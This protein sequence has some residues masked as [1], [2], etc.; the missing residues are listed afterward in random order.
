MTILKS[1]VKNTAA[2]SAAELVN[3]LGSALFWIAVV[4]VLG[5][6]GLGSLSFAMSLFALFATFSTFG[7]GAVLIR[8]VARDRSKAG[9]YFGHSMLLGL[10]SAVIAAALMN[11]AVL[12]LDT[13]R[14]T[15]LATRIMTT[16][17]LPASLFYWSKALLSAAEEMSK[18]ALARTAENLFKIGAGLAVLLAGGDLLLVVGVVAASK[19]VSA[20]VAF[21]YA[22]RLAAPLWRP[23]RPLLVYLLR[24]VPTFSLISI[25]NS[26]IWTMPVILLTHILGEGAAGV[27]SAAFKLVDL[28]LTFAAAYGQ[29]LFPIASRTLRDNRRV[30]EILFAKSVKV[31]FGAS[32]AL[33]AGI[34]MAAPQLVA[35][36]YGPGMENVASLLRLLVWMLIPYSIV[37]ILAHSLVSQYLQNRDLLANFLAAVAVISVTA[38][39]ASSL[40]PVSAAAGLLIGSTIFVTVELAAF[41]QRL[42]PIRLSP[43]MAK[44]ALAALFMSGLLFLLRDWNVFLSGSLA[45]CSYVGILFL[46]RY[47]NRYELEFIISKRRQ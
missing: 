16:A 18:T 10:G 44:P 43:E 9:A 19:W 17:L 27:F 31:V 23:R 28:L 15:V 40:G 34:S 33:A 13:S 45:A 14:E 3:R 42:M 35:L 22:R 1:L 8:D 2:R 47:I 25:F 4:R 32:L 26:L 20:L 5:T 46:V 24:Q 21:F 41:H 6:A 12:L 30:F 7:L 36:V 29:A 11:G 39:A 37:P 38:A